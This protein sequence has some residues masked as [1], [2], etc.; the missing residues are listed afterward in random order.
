MTDRIQRHGCGACGALLAVDNRGRLCSPCMRSAM[1]ERGSV[2]SLPDTFW[3]STEVK[4]TLAERHFGRLLRVYRMTQTPEIKQAELAV[5]L[6][7][8]Q[9]QVSRIE[10]GETP[11]R[12][13]DKLDRWARTLKIPQRC[14][15][16]TLS[17]QSPNAYPSGASTPN[18]SA[19][20]AHP[21]GDVHRR[22]F[23][24]S[25]ATVGA[26]L[27][28]RGGVIPNP[29]SATRAIGS[30]DVDL[31]REMTAAFRRVDNRYG[32][33]HS[34]SAV[35]SYITAT[36]EP[37]LAHARARNAV[38][39]DLFAA[40]A[41]LHQLAGWMAYDTGQADAGRQ[42]LRTALRLCQDAGD[43]ALGAEMLAG[44]SHHAAFHGVPESAIDLALAAHQSAKRAG[45]PALQAEA[46]VMEAH[47]LALRRDKQGCLSALRD[48]ETS[49]ASVD[50]KQLPS[51]LSYFDAAYLAAKFA[52]SFRDLGMPHDAEQ[53]AVRA[54]EMSDG[55]ERGRL[56]NTALLA[57][58]L[59]DQGRVEEACAHGTLAVQMTGTVR[60]VRSA[61]YLADLARRLATHRSHP[62]VTKLY[63][64]MVEIGIPVPV[65]GQLA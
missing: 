31:V 50:P 45:I 13:L 39:A 38:R 64:Q 53:F 11:T 58:I 10:R 59:A 52:H 57:S 17:A 34:R 26:S 47:G 14:L 55:Y 3:D 2:P 23:L 8:T 36:V 32:G 19:T 54:L 22:Q 61:A 25:A 1:S 51:W 24:K 30:P 56:F 9:G 40:S 62:G 4:E 16:F 6:E 63:R 20:Q 12:D 60:S 41:E 29:T 42:H 18:L 48:A 15:W 7:M 44:M 5:W 27:L 46:S 65:P 43:E 28:E 37:M 35:T 21:G 33:G 49:F